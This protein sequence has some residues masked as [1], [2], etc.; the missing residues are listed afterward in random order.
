MISVTY[1]DGSKFT[2]SELSKNQ[3]ETA[4]QLVTAQM[5]G[6]TT[7]PIT[8]NFT[9]SSGSNIATVSSASFLYVGQL[10]TAAALPTGTLIQ[11][12]NNLSITLSNAATSTISQGATV[13]DPLVWNKCRI[14]WQIEGQPGPDINSDT[15]TVQCVPIDTPF[16]RLRDNVG[17]IPAADVITQQ[18]V[19]TRTWKTMWTFYGPNSLTNAKLTQSALI[20]VPFIDYQLASNNLYVNPSIEEPLRNP[21]QF[22]GKWWERADLTAEFNEQITETLTIG[23]VGSVEVLVYDKDGQLEN[24]TVTT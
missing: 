11:S 10:V 24:F 16:S 3:M 14:A 15:V 8:I 17:L 23:T 9:F 7:T 2:S 12:I 20:K 5:L 18:D 22:Q 4:I 6:L 1:P 19:F 21:E 13:T